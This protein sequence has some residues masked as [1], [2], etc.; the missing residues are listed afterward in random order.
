VE[1]GKNQKRDGHH[2]D[3]IANLATLLSEFHFLALPVFAYDLSLSSSRGNCQRFAEFFL[4]Q[5]THAK[6]RPH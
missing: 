1:V 4:R 3:L 5:M 6:T 2:D